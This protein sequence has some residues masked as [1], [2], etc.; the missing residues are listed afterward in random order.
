MKLRESATLDAI[1]DALGRIPRVLVRRRTVGLFLAVD[2]SPTAALAALRHA[3]ISARVVEV[4]ITGEPDLDVL[5]GGQSCAT[6]GEPVHPKPVGLEVKAKAGRERPAQ[7][8]YRVNVAERRGIPHA[9]VRSPTEALIAC[10]LP[11]P[12]QLEVLP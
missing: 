12:F 7:A 5:V 1:A 11:V 9:I 4:G 6:C 8:A 2:A 3:G 10:G